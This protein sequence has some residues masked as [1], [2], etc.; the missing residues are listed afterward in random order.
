M[1]QLYIYFT[2][3]IYLHQNTYN[4]FYFIIFV[5]IFLYK[6]LVSFVF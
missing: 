4:I 5:L 1:L 2:H 3:N 6:L